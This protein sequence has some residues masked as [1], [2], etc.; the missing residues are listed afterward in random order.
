MALIMKTAEY[1]CSIFERDIMSDIVR[2]DKYL[3]D[4]SV[5]SRSEVKKY[6]KKGQ[7]R[8]GNQVIKDVRYKVDTKREVVYFDN[9]QLEYNKYIYLMLN[10]PAGVVSATQDNL[11]KTVIDLID[12]K[13]HRNIF[14]VGR[15]DKDTEGLLLI[16]NDGKLAHDLLSPKKQIPKTYYAVIDGRVTSREVMEFEKGIKI[17]EDFTT[18]PSKLKIL[19]SGEASKVEITIYEGKFHQ[20]KRMFEAVGMKVTYLKRISMA[21]LELDASL[22]LSSYRELTDD[23]LRMLKA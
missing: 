5:G 11:H 10:K 22:E 18:L 6:I 15:L 2:L 9:K 17:D 23:E 12:K 20:V 21:S 4:L 8:V 1:D 3:A 13:Y 19:E 16:T 7:V 14:P